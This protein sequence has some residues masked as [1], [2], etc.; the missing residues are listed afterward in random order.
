MIDIENLVIDRINTAVKSEYPSA[1]IYSTHVNDP[2]KMPCV[3]VYETANAERADLRT[4]DGEERYADISYSV[5]VFANGTNKKQTAKHIYDIVD[6]AMRKM[7]TDEEL[8]VC[9]GFNRIG[10]NYVFTTSESQVFLVAGTYAALVGESPDGAYS[11][12]NR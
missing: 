7:V 11:F 2:A 5:E 3:M 10:K 4:A 6:N 9:S 8:G 12:Y 1:V